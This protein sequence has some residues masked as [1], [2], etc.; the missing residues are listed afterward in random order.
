MQ[1]NKGY[2][3]TATVQH[4]D[5]DF[6]VVSLGD[7]AQLAVIQTRNHLN[8]VVIHESEKLDVGRTFPVQVVEASCEELQGLPLVSWEHRAPQRQRTTSEGQAGS[9]GHR[10]GEFLQCT[11]RAVKPTC[12]QVTLED[13]GKGSVH[14]SQVVE[15]SQVRVGSFPTS[16]VKVGSRV[17]ARVIGGW[18]ASSN[19]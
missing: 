7:T 11:V 8:E 5:T 6:A 13:G 4:V 15:P 18:E 16:S 2:R 9:R 1:L 10:F 12:I 19:R 17:T 3:Y 14:V